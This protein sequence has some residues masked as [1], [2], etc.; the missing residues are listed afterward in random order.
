MTHVGRE[1]PGVESIALLASFSF[2]PAVEYQQKD[3][4]GVTT[5]T[6]TGNGFESGALLGGV[7]TARAPFMFT[8]QQI[9]E[10][11]AA[12]VVVETALTAIN[13]YWKTDAAAPSVVLL[14]M[15]SARKALE[16]AKY[17]ADLVLANAKVSNAHGN[18]AQ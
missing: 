15:S 5:C 11:K 12:L 6:G 7:I 10:T 9:T 2:S 18:E 14:E 8:E 3:R 13:D 4:S 16:Q 17:Y 1:A